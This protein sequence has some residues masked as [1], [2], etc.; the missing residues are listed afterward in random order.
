M[1]CWHRVCQVLYLLHKVGTSMFPTVSNYLPMMV[2]CHAQTG[3]ICVHVHLKPKPR[4]GIGNGTG[5]GLLFLPICSDQAGSCIASK[6]DAKNSCATVGLWVPD[7]SR[8]RETLSGY[9]QVNSSSWHLS[10]GFNPSPKLLKYSGPEFIP[11][12]WDLGN[13]ANAP[14]AG[15]VFPMVDPHGE[16]PAANARG[17]RKWPSLKCRT[18][19]NTENTRVTRLKPWLSTVAIIIHPQETSS[20]SCIQVA[21]TKLQLHLYSTWPRTWSISVLQLA[22]TMTMISFRRFW[23]YP[24]PY[25][26]SET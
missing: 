8:K 25:P 9:Y 13:A 17:S 22:W 19:E 20:Q 15:W 12:T 21:P 6:V 14:W 7:P 16:V 10:T 24:H 5:E 3:H 23:N 18:L 4:G 2:C 26:P 11:L 1:S